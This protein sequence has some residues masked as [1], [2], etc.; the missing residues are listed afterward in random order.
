MIDPIIRPITK[1]DNPGIKQVIQTVMPE[2]GASGEGFAIHDEEVLDMHAA[3]IIKGAAYF[4]IEE[5]GKINGGGG[6]GPL[7]GGEANVCELKKMYLMPEA[8]GR[9]L[10]QLVL[11]RCLDFAISFGYKFCYLETFRTM[12]RALDF[13]R[14]NGFEQISEP[15][16]STGHF[17]CDKF[18]KKPLFGGPK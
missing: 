7:A 18:F 3:Y 6:I 16:G 10:G 4:V 5:N 8:R 15:M 11:D 17:S 1:G 14:K 13:Y 12:E 2:F 9:N